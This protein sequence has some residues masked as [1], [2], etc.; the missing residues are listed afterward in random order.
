MDLNFQL[1]IPTTF[2]YRKE[3][4]MPIQCNQR[5][6]KVEERV[7]SFPGKQTPAI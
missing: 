1:Y 7:I 4:A 3:S 5:G 2:P 6:L